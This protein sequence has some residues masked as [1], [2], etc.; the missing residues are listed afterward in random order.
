MIGDLSTDL[1]TKLKTITSFGTTPPRVG[2]T[3]GGKTLDPILEKIVKPACWVVFAGDQ[4][5][6]TNPNG[7]CPKI[8]SYTFIVKVIID[9]TNDNDMIA[10]Q[11]PVLEEVI[12]VL[13]GSQGPTKSE[14]WKYAGQSVEEITDRRL[15][16]NQT[17]NITATL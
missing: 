6:S 17:Y 12:S 2:L 7:R 13:D 16:F 8:F 5:T 1:L 11:F 3:I 14:K 9:Y 10:N 4:N 15:I